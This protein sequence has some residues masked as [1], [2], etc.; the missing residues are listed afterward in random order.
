MECAK[1]L[2]IYQ[3]SILVISISDV[4]S[5]PLTPGDMNASPAIKNSFSLYLLS[6]TFKNNIT[7]CLLFLF[8]SKYHSS[9]Q[10]ESFAIPAVPSVGP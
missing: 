8:V 1:I 6:Q 5:Q 7:Y 9:F 3:N 2:L 10:F 4:K